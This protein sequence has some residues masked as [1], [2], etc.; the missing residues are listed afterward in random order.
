MLLSSTV[1][2]AACGP[3][4]AGEVDAGA[5]GTDAGPS[6]AGAAAGP[7]LV[8]KREA[9][10]RTV[11]LSTLTT[12]A[13]G[14]KT[15]AGLDQVVAAAFP[16]ARG[17]GFHVGFQA[18]DGFDPSSKGGC[19]V[20]LP[21]AEALLPRGGIDPLTRNLAWDDALGYPGCLYLHDCATLTLE[22]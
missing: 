22:P 4:P 10:S 3:G 1:W 17:T 8:V 14:V 7:W 20:L 5:L 2:G 13:L 6:D 19:A 12:H 18:S 21:I 16:E 11:D 9:V 15:V